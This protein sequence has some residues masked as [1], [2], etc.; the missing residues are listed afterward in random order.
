MGLEFA[1][2]G[3]RTKWNKM[4]LGGQLK[5]H[6]VSE[7]RGRELTKRPWLLGRPNSLQLLTFGWILCS[8]LRLAAVRREVWGKWAFPGFL[9]HQISHLFWCFSWE[10]RRPNKTELV[11]STCYIH[12]L[13][14]KTK[15]S[16]IEALPNF[17]LRVYMAE[18]L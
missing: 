5:G 8:S 12:H 6:V 3:L 16:V 1:N 9:F 7:P 13:L 17:S 11:P 10:N 18:S 15:V 14:K 2:Q 4:D